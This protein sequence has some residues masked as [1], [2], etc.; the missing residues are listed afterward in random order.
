MIAYFTFVVNMYAR[1][2]QIVDF[3]L[4]FKR[5]KNMVQFTKNKGVI[6]KTLKGTAAY[7]GIG[8]KIEDICRHLEIAAEVGINSVFTSLQLPESDKESLLREFPIMAKKAHSLGIMVDADIGERSATLFGIGLHDF[9][10]FRELGLD[11]VRLDNGYTPEKIVEASYNKHGLIVEINAAHVTEESLSRLVELGINKEKIHFCHNYYPM[12]Y[13]GFSFAKAKQNN[14]LIHKFGFRVGGFIASSAHHRMGCGFGLP[15]IENHR[16]MHPF[17]SVQEGYLAGYDDMY[18][19][20]DFADVSELEILVNTDPSVL[21]LRMKP[22]VSDGVIDWVDGRSLLQTQYGL[23]MMVR[24]NF[25][26]CTYPG[27]VDGL[28]SAPRKRGDVTVCKSAYLRYKGEIQIVKK[29][30]PEDPDMATI[31]RILEEDIPLLDNYASP[32]PF[33]LVKV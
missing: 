3:V 15:T 8:N 7:C 16:Y 4:H 2:L 20:D 6:M 19:G 5:A 18:F 29:E 31:G 27:Y 22:T 1:F 33:M 12:R 30:M 9:D 13:T 23:E 25:D 21:K 32:K 10:A 26:K 24:S 14:D 11:I 17:I 28:K